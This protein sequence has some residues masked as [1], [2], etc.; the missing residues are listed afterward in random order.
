[1]QNA[2][3]LIEHLL[4]KG[5]LEA[6]IEGCL[7]LC[8]HYGDRER[9]SATAQHSA[10]YHTLM[11]DFRAGTLNDDDYRPERARINRAMLELAHDLPLEWTDEALGKAGFSALAYDRGSALQSK[12][13]GQK[14][15]IVLGVV[16][17]VAVAGFALKNVISS[18][19]NQPLVSQPVEPQANETEN[20]K[21]VE[22]TPK[23]TS[24]RPVTP[25]KTPS[26]TA[27]TKPT[28]GS[29]T[30]PRPILKNQ[31]INVPKVDGRFRSFANMQIKDDMERGYIDGK[32]AFR[33]VR[34]KE[35]ICCFSNA[36][37]FSGGKAYVSKDGVNYYFMDKSGRKV[38]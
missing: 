31:P 15:G 14:W 17:V 27:E 30:Q 33:N 9:S 23:E 37:D 28:D 1:M 13:G 38:E 16:A 5:K 2:R 26:T 22:T 36:E 6:A 8:R 29:S 21:Q 7:I 18:A 11:N 32:L 19:K 35:I 34:T 4:A 10:R 24:S 20:Q 12:S 25:S 3:H